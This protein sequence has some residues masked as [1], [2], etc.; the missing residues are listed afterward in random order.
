MNVIHKMFSNWLVNLSSNPCTNIRISFFFSATADTSAGLAKIG[1]SGNQQRACVPEFPNVSSTEEVPK[2]FC[3]PVGTP[4]FG[5]VYKPE[6]V[7]GQVASV[8]PQVRRLCNE[9][10]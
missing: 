5:N 2:L 3:F 6:R 4:V 8:S 9:A 1:P 7:E 10:N